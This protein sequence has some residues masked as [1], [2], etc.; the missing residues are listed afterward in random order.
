MIANGYFSKDEPDL[1]KSI[2]NDLL[3]NDYYLLLADF[4]AYLVA[5]EQVEETFKDKDRWCKMS[6]INC[7][8][9]GIFSSDRT[10]EEYNRDIW[11]SKPVPV[12]LGILNK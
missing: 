12:E 11:K 2:T 5:Q 3:N 1:F 8:N 6:I 4:Q 10:I 9:M 7:A